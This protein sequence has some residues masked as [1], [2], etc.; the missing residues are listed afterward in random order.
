MP[1]P[2]T[3]DIVTW[4]I[5]AC[6]A[7]VLLVK[8]WPVIRRAVSTGDAIGGLPELVKDVAELKTLI[9]EVRNEVKNSHE[10]NLRD[11]LDDKHDVLIARMDQADENA[12][13][14]L[15]WSNQETNRLWSAIY[16]G[17]PDVGPPKV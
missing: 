9:V 3:P 14:H 17:P 13:K 10:M 7:L 12:A 2:E 8:V 11:D 15:A 4:I 1:V 5:T 6:L 16:D